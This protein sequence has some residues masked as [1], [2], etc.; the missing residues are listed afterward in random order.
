[1]YLYFLFIKRKSLSHVLLLHTPPVCVCVCVLFPYNTVCMHCMRGSVC[2]L[3]LTL[4][5]YHYHY[6]HYRG[7]LILILILILI[8]YI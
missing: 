4:Y 5:H 6:H 1:M 2:F 7:A 3:I 8:T